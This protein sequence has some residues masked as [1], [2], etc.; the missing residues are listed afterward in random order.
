MLI[1]DKK[2]RLNEKFNSAARYLEEAKA[3]IKEFEE[4]S[5]TKSYESEIKR[6]FS[7]DL[8]SVAVVASESE[9]EKASA[10]LA[11]ASG[12][13]EFVAKKLNESALIT[14]IDYLTITST[15]ENLEVSH[16]LEFELKTSGQSWSS[17]FSKFISK[18]VYKKLE[19]VGGK[20]DGHHM[21]NVTLIKDT[22]V[23]VFTYQ[24]VNLENNQDM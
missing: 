17:I 19:R 4:L 20:I 7:E 14:N 13:F 22:F 5:V 10:S 18:E 9:Y 3:K 2:D 12:I 16:V 8:C 24:R 15:I 1:P 23:F 6:H 11:Y 21:S